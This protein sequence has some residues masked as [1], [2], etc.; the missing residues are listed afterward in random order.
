M[1]GSREPLSIATNRRMMNAYQY[2]DYLR[3]KLHRERRTF[4]KRT[5]D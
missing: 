1:D 4:E 2:K 5:Y 3:N